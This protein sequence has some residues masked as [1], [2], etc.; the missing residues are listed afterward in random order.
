[1]SDDYLKIIPMDL[2]HV[3]PVE[4]H[5]RAVAYLEHL[6]P[7]GEECAVDIYD[8]V[9][10]IDQ[11]EN[12]EAVICPTCRAR[13]EL[14]HLCDDD[15][16]LQWWHDVGDQMEQHPVESIVTTMP[17]CRAS[18]RLVDMAF[19]WPAG[20]ARFEVSIRNPNASENLSDPQLVELSGILGCTLRQ[21]RAHY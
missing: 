14:D 21:V 10:F 12:M 3:P 6:F 1:M 7:E 16:T 18:V 15:S 11:G 9:R 2:H 20:F 19:D 13:L 17:C 5:A 4:C 8:T